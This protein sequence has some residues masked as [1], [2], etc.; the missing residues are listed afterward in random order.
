MKWRR[1]LAWMV[2]EGL[3]CGDNNIAK[4]IR[5]DRLRCGGGDDDDG[6]DTNGNQIRRHRFA[7][8]V[9]WGVCVCVAFERGS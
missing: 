7:F 9:R 1:R 2:T 8:L 4:T 6:D 5:G 3:S